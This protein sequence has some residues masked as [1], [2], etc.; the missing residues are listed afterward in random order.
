MAGM[1]LW[2]RVQ[3]GNGAL[4][5]GIDGFAL[6][7]TDLGA[8]LFTSSGPRGGVAAYDLSGGAATLVGTSWFAPGWGGD[9]LSEPLL[10]EIGDTARL[11]VTGSGETG[12]RTLDPA[13]PGNL[14]TANLFADLA[15]DLGRLR[16]AVKGAD[17]RLYLA[18]GATGG[19]TVHDW[20]GTALVQVSSVV[21]TAWTY[22]ADV[23][24]LA[25]AH[26]GHATYLI[27]ASQ[28][29]SG[30][31]AFRL[32]PDGLTATGSMG[33]DEGLGVMVP[34]AMELVE[35][36]GRSFVVLA[37]AADDGSSGALSVMEL[38]P[39]G[40]LVPTDH[41]IDTLATRFGTV[42]DLAVAVADG[43]AFV[44]AGGGDDGLSLFALLPNGRLHLLETVGADTE[45]ELLDI[46]RLAAWSDGTTLSLY[47]ASESAPGIAV[48]TR[49]ISGQ[50]ASTVA[51]AGGGTTTGTAQGD[52]LIGGDGNYLLRGLDGDDIL[53]DGAG[54]D[55]LEG[56]AGADR[57]LLRA[58]GAIDRI[59]DFE[60][61]IDR[62]DL[63]D[64]P[65]LYDAGQ[66]TITPTATGATVVW[67]DET[68]VID[69]AGGGPISATEIAAALIESPH[70]QP[71]LHLVEA[72]GVLREGGGGADALDGGQGDDTLA[73]HAG[74]D[75]L[76][77]FA[78]ADTL[79][80]GAG[81]DRLEGGA[82]ADML[83]GGTEVDW[84]LYDTS[85]EGVTVRLWAGD[86]TGGDAQ[87]DTLTG[88]ENLGGSRFADVLAGDA[89]ANLLS[90]G[91][92]DDSLWGNAGDDTLEG[93]P[94]AD[95]LQGQAGFDLATYAASDAGVLVRLWAGDGA[96][97]DAEGDT[98]VGIEALEG[99]AHADTLVG[100]GGGNLLLG[101]AGNDALWGNDGDDTLVGG[102]GADA[103]NGQGGSDWA[104]YA[105]SGA[106]VSVRL[107]AGDGTGGDAQG[108]TLSGI[109]HLEGSAHAD[110]LVGDGGANHLMG[111]TGNDALWGNAGNDTLEGGPGADLLNG[112][113]GSDWASYAGSASGVTVRLWAG[114]G[115]G[116][117]AEGDTLVSIENLAGSAHADLL[118]G[119]AGANRIHGGAGDDDIWANAG[120]DTLEGGA[121]AD[122]LRGQG[123]EDVASYAGSSAGVVVRLW[124]G[125][126]R[127]GDAEGDTLFDI[128]HL[129]GSAHADTLVGD[130]GGNRLM[131]G[132][133]NDALW[134]NGGDD[135]L[136]GGAGDDVLRGQAGD[137]LLFG[138]PGADVFVFL[139]GDG[140]DTIADFAPGDLIDLRGVAGFNAFED[141]QAAA[142]DG[143]GGVTI[144]TGAGSILIANVGLANLD[145]TDFLF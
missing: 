43:H 39:S 38:L 45:P 69:R 44:A 103:L 118:V 94:G 54:A 58:D 138:G 78:G 117:D 46:A 126:G 101:G 17:G 72:A 141:V 81:R 121:G 34:T 99:S 60:P 63:S 24:G 14:G 59:A 35:I 134:G 76:R 32:D 57:F 21:D 74:D 87:G 5:A 140:H 15:P 84:A 110:T 77:G 120:N 65:L 95:L 75:V 12:L 91:D 123:G 92:G 109:E 111:G 50:G 64:W 7:E 41:V 11:V 136:E 129:E 29:E 47:T 67:R 132:G 130:G 71:F 3:S 61:G 18:D 89:G 90:G 25:T 114:S 70:R 85:P 102:P 113:D 27:A 125:D 108:D 131:G 143:P 137:D 62:L 145:L 115:A 10:L 107:W 22:A 52:I 23:F 6:V 49:D 56:G 98:L 55:T 20:T 144:D 112:Q 139:D 28:G 119:D 88:I 122:R 105:T 93:G 97:G 104:S 53:E 100:D 13:D 142:E 31:T 116:G 96:G 8:I 73:G 16:D 133:G 33:A 83:D 37:S 1:T 68:L 80:G 30:V 106:G 66:L 48:F 2:G 135:T 4:D 124:A 128:E 42:Q 79:L 51:V 36:G 26:A 82:G 127:G 9:A 40:A 19:V 86:G